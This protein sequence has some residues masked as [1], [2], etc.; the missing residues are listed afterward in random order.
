MKKA[1]RLSGHTPEEHTGMYLHAA[2]VEHVESGV[3]V[4]G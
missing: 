3:H 2:R 1:G 4:L